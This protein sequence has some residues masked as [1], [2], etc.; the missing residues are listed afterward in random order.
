MTVCFYLR[1]LQ[2]A[3]QSLDFQDLSV[4]KSVKVLIVSGYMEM[5]NIDLVDINICD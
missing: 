3:F 1:D 5:L 4:S 2:R